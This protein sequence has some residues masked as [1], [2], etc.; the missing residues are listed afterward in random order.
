MQVA[1]MEP[2]GVKA[3]LKQAYIRDSK[4]T[5]EDLVKETAVKVKEK[6]VVEEIVRV[7]L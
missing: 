1:S 5:I 4:M 7:S 2:K 3:L 6:I